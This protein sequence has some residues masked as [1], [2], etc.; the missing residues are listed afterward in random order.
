MS[1]LTLFSWGY[2]G[3]GN[4]IPQLL[5]ATQTAE[6]A[7]GFLPP[8]FVDIR[9][10]R[11]VRAEGFKEKAFEKVL[12]PERYI[13]LKD[14]GNANIT[15]ADATKAK[16]S[17]KNA[18]NDLIDIAM[19]A[20]KKNQRLIFFCSCH[21]Q[22]QNCHRHLVAKLTLQAAKKRTIPLTI[23]EWPGDEPTKIPALT[24]QITKA[25][26]NKLLTEQD[27]PGIPIEEKLAELY[28]ALP[29]GSLVWVQE[30]ER[31][32][33][34]G[35]GPAMIRAGKWFLPAIGWEYTDEEYDVNDFHE[36]INKELKKIKLNLFTSGI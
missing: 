3:W 21:S 29:W 20:A 15:D 4:S 32:A 36:F 17:N 5:H 7:R 25:H 28:F 12:G 11:A 1:K 23:A 35:T 10:R 6:Q 27:F 18:V 24:F 16:I 9:F 22:D 30:G 14:L 31:R 34:V 2:K 33:L 26:F 8:L 19:S 13:W